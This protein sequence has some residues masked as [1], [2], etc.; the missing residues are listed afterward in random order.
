MARLSLRD[1]AAIP[2][3]VTDFVAEYL[4]AVG[5]N[6]LQDELHFY[7]DHVDYFGQRMVDR[8]VIEQSLRKY[9]QHWPDRSYS[10][11]RSVS[12]RL[13]PDRGEIVLTFLVNFS[14]S[15]GRI[16]VKGQTENRLTINAA[17]EDP[18]IVGI[19]ERRVRH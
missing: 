1:S 15:H 12:Y 7:A 17:T 18:R 19:E 10:L 9:Y 2:S 3:K 6:R 8:R 5:R 11:V 14:L 16:R 4:R 13:A